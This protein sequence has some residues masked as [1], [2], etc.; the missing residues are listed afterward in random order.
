MAAAGGRKPIANKIFPKEE[1]MKK[2]LV[3]AVLALTAGTM[4]FANGG[5]EQTAAPAAGG[6][7]AAASS[8]PI[9]IVFIPKNLGNP[10]FVAMSGGFIKELKNLDPGGTEGANNT[11]YKGKKFDYTFTG[12]ATPDATSQIDYVNAAVQNKAAAVFIAANSNDALDQTFDDA[13]AAGTKI[14]I[15]N[16]DIP[17]NESH[18]DAAI[19]PC[20][21][22][23]AGQGLL[24][25]AMDF[26]GGGGE[27]AILTATTDAPDQNYWCQQMV[28]LLPAANLPASGLLFKQAAG[29]SDSKYANMKLDA[30]VYGNDEPAKSTTEMEGLIAKFPNLKCVIAPTTVGIAACAKVIKDKGLADKISL[31]G[32]GL[33]SEMKPYI[34]DGTCKGFQ[35]WDNP[36]EG[37]VAVNLIDQIVNNGFK[38]T[39]GASF[40]AG[41]LGTVKVEADHPETAASNEA[42]EI[43]T[44]AKPKIFNKDNLADF[45]F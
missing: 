22:V 8:G 27:F 13:R 29:K 11:S 45:T 34:L 24:D 32:F 16:Q 21:F 33:P 15:I 40:K 12:P 6:A 14:I 25:Q 18:R 36:G 43:F 35:L 28:D 19:M 42:G 41:Y 23:T 31:T 7:A 3:M 1:K 2:F 44:L 10:Y 17:G 20:N 26:M 4:V 38:V 5:S 37:C 9:K 30:V 39:P